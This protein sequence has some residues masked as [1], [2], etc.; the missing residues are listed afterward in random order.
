MVTPRS[1]ELEYE[2]W[3]KGI[4][5]LC[6]SDQQSSSVQMMMPCTTDKSI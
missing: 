5:G 1:D 2:K 4:S 3:C 6:I